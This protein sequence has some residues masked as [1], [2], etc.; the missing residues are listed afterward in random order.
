[1]GNAEV[2]RQVVHHAIL[3]GVGSDTLPQGVPGLDTVSH[4]H[5][6]VQS[7]I[8]LQ[9]RTPSI[10]SPLLV[11]LVRDFSASMTPLY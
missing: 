8:E 5:R 2:Q 1:V 3:Y 4:R 11:I 9:V 10:L 6:Q 7:D